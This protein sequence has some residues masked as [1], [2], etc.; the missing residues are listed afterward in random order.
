M[1]E[2]GTMFSCAVLTAALVEVALRPVLARALVAWLRAESPAI[3]AALLARFAAP[4]FAADGAV[5]PLTV[6]ARAL[7]AWVPL[8]RPP[9]LLTQIWSSL[10]ARCQYCGATP[11]TPWYWVRGVWIT[12]T[13]RRPLATPS[14]SSL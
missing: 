2:S 11:I 3:C 1:A 14:V 5:G 12:Q 9:G 6:P 7:V 13:R 10:S 4:V 8:T